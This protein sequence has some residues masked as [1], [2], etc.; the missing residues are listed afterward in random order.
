M[1]NYLNFVEM[2]IDAQRLNTTNYRSNSCVK[3]RTS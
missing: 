2:R 1:E 3:Y